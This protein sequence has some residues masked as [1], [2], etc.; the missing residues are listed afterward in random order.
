MKGR[1]LSAGEA[2]GGDDSS[3]RER[4][5]GRPVQSSSLTAEELFAQFSL[6]MQGDYHSDP[7]SA[8]SGLKTG[9]WLQIRAMSGGFWGLT[10]TQSQMMHC[11]SPRPRYTA[12][13]PLSPGCPAA[14]P[15]GCGA[16]VGAHRYLEPL[17][18]LPH[19]LKNPRAKWSSHCL[20]N[21][22]MYPQVCTELDIL[23]RFHNICIYYLM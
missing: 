11:V 6:S 1:R 13:P 15:H 7:R 4:G 20:C 9:V 18:S 10:E 2:G 19:F 17:S 23:Q 5:G 8:I 12:S 21:S 3:G 16:R 22:D 14:F